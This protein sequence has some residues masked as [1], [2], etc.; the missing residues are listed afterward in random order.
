MADFK[1]L[2]EKF[3]CFAK[4]VAYMANE[5]VEV[6]KLKS[7]I[8]SNQK[9][10]KELYAEIG[11]TIYHMRKEGRLEDDRFYFQC[12]EI[13]NLFFEISDIQEQLN[14]IKGYATCT[15]CGTAVSRADSFCSK[16]GSS[17]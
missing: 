1:D 11:K 6:Q 5:A 7:K 13:E 14:S 8:R 3:E 10:I 4:D 17:L 15:H 16:C 2:G 12:E 9:D